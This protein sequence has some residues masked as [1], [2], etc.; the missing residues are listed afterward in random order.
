MANDIV[1]TVDEVI[2]LNQL[3]ANT[4]SK[5]IAQWI[6][7][8]KS[9]V[10]D[11][12]NNAYDPTV[13]GRDAEYA[14]AIKLYTMYL[15]MDTPN[16]ITLVGIGQLKEETVDKVYLT[17][18]DVIKKQNAVLNKCNNFI[19]II[20][21]AMNTIDTSTLDMS[22]QLQPMGNAMYVIG[23]GGNKDYKT[24]Y[25]LGMQQDDD[26]LREVLPNVE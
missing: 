25:G 12:L 17:P 16:F 23:M 4:D 8:A 21:K 6:P 24:N 10:D 3:P 14:T 19:N 2:S 20:K 5:A 26:D 18:D 13:H 9:Y 7:L 15:Y 11:E 1:V 22:D